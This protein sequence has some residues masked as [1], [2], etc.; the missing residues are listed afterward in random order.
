MPN[1]YETMVGERGVRVS[2]GQKQRLFIARE[3]YKNPNL[4]ILDEATSALDSESE[5]YIQESIDNLKRSLTVVII[6]HR[7]STIKNADIIYVMDNG[8]I[9]ESGS[10]EELTSKDHSRFSKMVN[11]Q[12]I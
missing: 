9:I 12:Q 10:F 6:A 4:L 8:V 7:L 1:G 3:L 11:I 2:G 5:R